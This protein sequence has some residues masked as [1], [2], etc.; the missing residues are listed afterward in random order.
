MAGELIKVTGIAEVQKMLAEAPKSVVARGYLK[1]LDAGIKVFEAY[2]ELKTPIR[3]GF[4]GEDLMVQGG[5]LKAA[6]VSQVELDSQF[7]GGIAA[8]GYGKLGY[9]A[10]FVEYGHRIVKPGGRYVNSRGKS[11]KGTVTGQVP[12][13][14]F[15]RPA[16]D[17]QADAALDAFCESLIETLKGGV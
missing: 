15:M 12:A 8:V 16:F 6:L 13:Y 11:R 7:R 17:T 9:I 14:P 2:L 3:L 10:N 4:E 5:D 1:A